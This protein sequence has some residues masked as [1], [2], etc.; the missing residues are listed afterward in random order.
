M[1]ALAAREAGLAAVFL[2]LED[3][4]N[5]L[6]VIR[7]VGMQ[8]GLRVQQSIPQILVPLFKPL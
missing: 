2:S 3:M 7:L 5:H 6:L 1:Q 8:V 4:F